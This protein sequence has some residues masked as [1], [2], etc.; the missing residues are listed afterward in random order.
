MIH[1]GLANFTQRAS[2]TLTCI[3]CELTDIKISCNGDANS[4]TRAPP[5]ESCNNMAAEKER[6]FPP[7]TVH[8][9]GSDGGGREGGEKKRP[10]FNFAPMASRLSKSRPSSSLSLE[11]GRQQWGCCKEIATSHG[12]AHRQPPQRAVRDNSALRNAADVREGTAM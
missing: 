4:S 9:T 6:Q 5:P 1:E 11:Q 3:S 10:A 2:S 12:T 8:M 7:S